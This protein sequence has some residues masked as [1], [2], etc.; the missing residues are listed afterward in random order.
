MSH[1]KLKV[2][3]AEPN[4]TSSMSINVA[5]LNDVSGTPTTSQ[6]LKY[7]GSSWEAVTNGIVA[8]VS[9]GQTSRL[10]NDLVMVDIR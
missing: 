3:T 6:Y 2:G 7:N 8:P 10:V 4:I 9:R 5:D 1:N